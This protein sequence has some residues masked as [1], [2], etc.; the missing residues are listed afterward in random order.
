MPFVRRGAFT[1][2]EG[3]ISTM[4]QG[5]TPHCA[6]VRLSFLFLCRFMVMPNQLESD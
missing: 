6:A 5:F 4:S 3:T 1:P 2:T